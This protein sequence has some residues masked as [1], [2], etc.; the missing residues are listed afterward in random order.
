[1]TKD[2]QIELAVLVGK[3]ERY[4]GRTEEAIKNS[5]EHMRKI[6][7]NLTLLSDSFQ[8]HTVAQAAAVAAMQATCKERSTRLCAVEE[9]VRELQQESCQ[10]FDGA[11][12]TPI[13]AEPIPPMLPKKSTAE[14]RA[15]RA[16]RMWKWVR[17]RTST[18]LAVIVLGC[19]LSGAAVWMV[20]AYNTI[21]QMQATVTH[22]IN[23]GGSSNPGTTR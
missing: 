14:I 21:E 6:D 2:E 19:T 3:V 9:C 23:D 5:E 8:K 1:M 16:D 4:A 22:A 11:I 15:A 20:K 10:R 7:L 13:Q 18:I 12:L 17:D